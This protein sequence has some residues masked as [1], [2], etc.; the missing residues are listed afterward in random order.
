VADEQQLRAYLRRVTVELAEERK[1][2]HAYRSEPIAIVGMSCRYPGDVDSPE[3]LWGLVEQ[4]RDAI[5]EFPRDRGWDL[6]RLYDPDPDN[7]GTSYVREGGFLA[8]VGDFDPAFF[9]MGPRE[10]LATDPQQRLLL[11]TSWEALE[12]AHIDP[13]SLGKTQTGVFAGAFYPDYV[14]AL[15]AAAEELEGH[16]AAGAPVSIVSGRVAYTL[17]LEGPAITLDTAC[18]S[19]LV[20]IHLASQALR[21]GECSLALA[22]GVTVLSTPMVFCGLSRQRVLAPDGRSKSFA[23]AADGVGWS[24]GVGVLALQRLSDAERDG[25]R[26]LA[27]IRGSAVNQ[28]GASNGLIAPSGP[29]QER[30]IRQAL[31]NAR[32]TA[33]DV[34]VVEAHGTGTALGDPIEAG[35]LLATYGQDRE[36]PLRLGSIKSNIG[37]TQAAA[38]VAGVIKMVMAM[39]ERVLPKT[40]HVDAPSSKIEWDQGRVELLTEPLEWR[41]NGRPRRAAVSSFGISGTNAHLILEEAPPRSPKTDSTPSGEPAVGQGEP[42]PDTFPLVLSA[43]SQSSLSEAAAR[44]ASHLRDGS[45]PNLGDVAYSLATGRAHFEERAAVI[46]AEREGLLA[47]LDALADGAGHSGLVRG[48]ARSERRPV[49]LFPGQGAQHVGMAIELFDSSPVFRSHMRACEEA[50]EPFVEWSLEEVLRSPD[51]AWLERMD[52]V[53]PALFAVMVSLARLWEATGVIP[54]AVV[55]HSQGEIAAALIAGGLGLD[56]ASRIVAMRSRRLTGIAGKGG[57]ISVALPVA[58]LPSLL[59][60]HGDRISLAA[61]NGPTS[62]VL[63]GELEPLERLLAECERDGVYA[64]RV[65][66]LC[67]GHSVQI[68]ALREG[69]LGDFASISPRSGEIP[70]HSTVTGEP[71]DTGKLDAEYWYGNLRGTVRLEP[72]LRA[73]LTRGTRTVIEVSPHPMLGLAVQETID[74]APDAEN[75]TVLGTL[76]RGD[77]GTERFALSLGQAHAAGAE[78]DWNGY[79][80][81]S[82]AEPV[83]LPTYPFQR[84]RF[85]PATATGAGDVSAAGLHATRH[86]LLGASIEDPEGGGLTFVGRISRQTHSWLADHGAAGMVFL[87][88][89]AFVELALEAGSEAGCE[90]LRELTL[91]A[92]LVLS[93]EGGVRLQVS[94]SAGGARGERA[95]SIYSQPEA[96]ESGEWTSHA[97]GVL[98]AT[99]AESEEQLGVWPPPG[100]SPLDVETIHARLAETGLSYG[101]AFLG[102]TAAWRLEDEVFAEVS[103]APEQAQMARRFAVHPA[104]LEA[105]LHAG[106]VL[107]A[108]D[109]DGDGEA[110]APEQPF[111]WSGVRLGSAR[112]ASL[113]VRLGRHRDSLSFTAFDSAGVLALS[114]KSIG[115][116]RLDLDRLRDA[117]AH[118][119]L[120]RL[121]WQVM[122]PPAGPAAEASTVTLGQAGSGAGSA[123]N[124]IEAAH[125]NVR[126]A[127]ALLREKLAP[128][129]L[130][131]GRLAFLTERAVAA[132]D[133]AVDL[134]RAPLWGLLCSAQFEHPGRFALIDSDGSEAS[135]EALPSALALC[136]SEPQLA[137]RGGRLLAPRIR[138]AAAEAGAPRRGHGAPRP[139]DPDRTVLITG[140]TG[141]LGSLLARHLVER[142]AAR[143]LVLLSRRGP[144]A[145]GAAGLTAELAELG[146][147]VRIEACDVADRAQLE[148]I[149]CSIDPE[150]PLGAVIHAAGAL[151]DGSADSTGEEELWAAFVPKLDAAWHLHELTGDLDLSAF[152]LFSSLA[153]TL[154]G[155][156]QAGF[157][158][159]RSFL[160]ALARHRHSAGLP[161]TSIG[162]GLWA[163]GSGAGDGQSLWLRRFGARELSDRQ[164]LRLFDAALAAG[165]PSS[166]AMRLDESGFRALEE[167]GFLPPIL[168]ELVP[169]D[170]AELRRAPTVPLEERL[171]KMPDEDR[172][173]F[174]LELVRG[175]VAAVLGYDDAAEIDPELLFN[176][177]GF[178]SLAAVEMCNRL[179]EVTGRE[180]PV[181]LVFDYPSAGA[182]SAYLLQELGKPR[183]GSLV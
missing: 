145:E 163:R 41:A 23:E 75:A 98:C 104:L 11:E 125:A 121:Q 175:Q 130:E 53:Q 66:A 148:A 37:H 15:G 86:P 137:I 165:E 91:S 6:E 155:P 9:R 120:Y 34:D 33:G 84:K 99:A 39:R 25:R 129:P 27:T 134:A 177:L 108:G 139:I 2:L 45:E 16:M 38:G 22:G 111:S 20:A 141:G 50:L 93:E 63:S 107:P 171:A 82:A 113:R 157:A 136:A 97:R 87:P 1:R 167:A 59:E 131:S 72:V 4:G 119:S 147:E 166:E 117:A 83:A 40:L 17:G 128:G 29:A 69:L 127:V 85:W 116:G 158:V 48:R 60:P 146:A 109:G 62:L 103:L 123:A 183:E 182:I 173:P 46:G 118:S 152:V 65:A 153:G 90:A 26:V 112:A 105:A 101:P 135:R 115:F 144:D 57:M 94:L 169:P 73:L 89:A 18:S 49:F 132:S 74:A 54:A 151:A 106:S 35:A 47:G 138:I 142:H 81:G 64:K 92:P 110:R 36:E 71:L 51:D 133:E 61:I 70:F 13:L 43:K 102:L 32:L 181:A 126:D 88:A 122:E 14:N 162:W 31:A 77:G 149:L 42:L 176:E 67:A 174:V 168:R 179:G 140:G 28:D 24:E 80:A 172:E 160:D 78:V 56:D 12:E 114:A 76:R 96:V 5:V 178:D 7:P 100:A 161:A 150:H 55:G 21:A 143:H 124:P 30:V 52:V 156:G 10:A 3:R 154:G 95:I 159:A 170:R 68:E 19:S 44:L 58:E 79:F 8:G 180:I 164:G